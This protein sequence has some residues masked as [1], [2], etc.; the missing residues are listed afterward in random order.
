MSKPKYTDLL[1]KNQAYENQTFKKNVFEFDFETDGDISFINCVFKGITSFE[2]IK[3]REVNFIGCTFENVL[4]ISKSSFFIFG[5]SDCKLLKDSN[6]KSNICRSYTV[7]RSLI[8]GKVEISGTYQT[9]QL[10]T[11]TIEK[12]KLIDVNSEYSERDSK[13]EFLVENKLKELKIKSHSNFSNIIFK[14]GE[15]EYIYFDGIFSNSISFDKKIKNE[16]LF[17]E[18]SVFKS[19]IDFN[20]GEFKYINLYR[21]SFHGLV[22]F[23]GFN[24]LDKLEKDISIQNLTIH[25]SYF[26]KDVRV[27]VLKIISFDLSNNNFKQIFNLNN[28]NSNQDKLEYSLAKR[29]SLSGSNQGNIIIEN[30]FADLNVSDINFGNIYFKNI[31][32][33]T[34]YINQFH[35]KG[36]VSFTNINS[37]VH[38]VIQDSIVGN[39]NLLNEDLNMF[40]EIVIANSNLKGINISIYPKKIRSFSSNPKVGYGINDKSKNNQNLKNVYNQLKQV[41]KSNGDIDPM[42]KYKSLELGKLIKTKKISFDSI[43][44]LLNWISNNNGQ[45]WFRGVLFTLIIAFLFFLLYLKNLGIPINLNEHYKDYISFISSFPKLQLEKFSQLNKLWNVSLIIWLSRI[46]ISYGIY[47]TVSAFR[48]YG[49]G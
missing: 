18:S 17:F 26:E 36:N 8:G 37:G 44:L 43:L 46:F 15:Y 5:F 47:Q 20:E 33:H 19:R 9:F 34:L 32:L 21:S 3:A 23:N 48:K 16:Y 7:F 27:S 29:L 40:S 49:K 1:N 10:V 35:N 2:N 13:I 45:S 31:D 12:L 24:Y 39:F 30:I 28:H 25:S 22:M 14:G 4:S 42:N 11:S 6:F 41:A 38:L